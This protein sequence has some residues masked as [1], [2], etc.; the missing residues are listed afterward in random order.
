MVSPMDDGV[1]TA[2]EARQG[3][4]NPGMVTVLRVSILLTVVVF[5][6]LV[7]FFWARSSGLIRFSTDQ[8]PIAAER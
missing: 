1:E 8:A 6:L 7:A 5:A 2:E 4:N 3:E